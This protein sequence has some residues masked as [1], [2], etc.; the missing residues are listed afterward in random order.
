MES[1]QTVRKRLLAARDDSPKEYRD[2]AS[3]EISRKLL[4]AD[5]YAE[6]ERI[7]VYAAI[8]REVDLSA[9]IRQAWA[10]GKELYFP[11]VCGDT[12]EFYRA[13]SFSELTPGAFGVPEPVSTEPVLRM[14]PFLTP[15][16]VPGVAFSRDNHRIGYGKGYYD[17]YLLAN[18]KNKRLA[19]I[20]VAFSFQIVDGFE[21]EPT[22][23]PVQT[24]VTD[25]T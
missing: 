15:I 2:R 21:T 4:D 16:L 9:F 14:I 6:S 25:E 10:D 8:R 18:Q 12:M 3:E 1:K 24:V 13:D 11:K 5:W 20:G 7:F 17:R 22:D 23:Y 19:A